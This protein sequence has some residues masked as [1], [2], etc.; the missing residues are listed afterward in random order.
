[1]YYVIL[2][3]TGTIGYCFQRY[4]SRHR[5]K[6]ME[7]MGWLMIIATSIVLAAIKKVF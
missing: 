6:G 1:M 5:K 4:G 3:A 2:T 7:I